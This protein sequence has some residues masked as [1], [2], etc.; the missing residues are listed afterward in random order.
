M[1]SKTI[2]YNG[3]HNI[4]R[5]SH[6][7]VNEKM[8]SFCNYRTWS[9]TIGFWG[10]NHFQT[11]PSHVQPI[12]KLPLFRPNLIL[13]SSAARILGEV[14]ASHREV[15]LAAYESC[16][17]SHSYHPNFPRSGWYEPC[18]IGGLFL[19]IMASCPTGLTL[20]QAHTL[21]VHVLARKS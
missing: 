13:H 5:Q 6:L 17:K 15:D 8:S 11:H 1:I 4:F 7:N 9:L 12:I 14:P 2:G 10:T 20:L 16:N 19:T 18:K 21:D 3:V